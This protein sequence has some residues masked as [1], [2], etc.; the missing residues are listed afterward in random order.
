MFCIFTTQSYY[1]AGLWFKPA[2]P[3]LDMFRGPPK[4]Q[5]LVW[6]PDKEQHRNNRIRIFTSIICSVGERLFRNSEM[7]C[8]C[9]W[10]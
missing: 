3:G 1:K 9:F 6:L 2:A 10:S 7:L 4:L 8:H 5:A